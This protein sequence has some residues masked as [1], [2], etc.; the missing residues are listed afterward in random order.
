MQNWIPL[1]GALELW[2]A[3]IFALSVGVELRVKENVASLKLQRGMEDIYDALIQNSRYSNICTLS[4]R[5]AWYPR[6]QVQTL[7]RSKNKK[8][9][10]EA[11]YCLDRYSTVISRPQWQRKKLYKGGG[12]QNMAWN[13]CVALKTVLLIVG[14]HLGSIYSSEGQ[15]AKGG[16]K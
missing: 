6:K 13:S 10:Q 11:C 14:V 8:D 9:A 4:G 16:G 2:Q 15:M 12:G 3:A 1:R 7:P 5:T